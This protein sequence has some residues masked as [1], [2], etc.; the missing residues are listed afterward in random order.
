VPC[1]FTV[2]EGEA[3]MEMAMVVSVVM[4]S[5]LS[6]LMIYGIERLWRQRRPHT[7]VIRHQLTTTGRQSRLADT[8]KIGRAA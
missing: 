7:R 2:R 6:V 5:G 3:M 8:Y 1:L 4:V